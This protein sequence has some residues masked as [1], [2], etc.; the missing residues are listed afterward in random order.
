MILRLKRSI[1]QIRLSKITTQCDHHQLL[2][3]TDEVKKESAM[4]I[5]VASALGFS[6]AGRT[7]YYDNLIPTLQQGGHEIIDPW[8]VVD[9]ARAR[10]IATMCSGLEKE[11]AW[12]H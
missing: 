1:I 5:Y 10:D 4:R 12:R 7:F 9:S 8:S 3:T 6:E 2:A 11:A